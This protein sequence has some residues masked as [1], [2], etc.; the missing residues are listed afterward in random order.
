MQLGT[1]DTTEYM[2]H[3]LK[4][5][6]VKVTEPPDEQP[7]ALVP[8]TQRSSLKRTSDMNEY[9]KRSDIL[10]K[11]KRTKVYKIQERTTKS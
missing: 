7:I 5:S 2:Q 9:M 1:M 11:Q 8:G 10:K 3:E 6:G 4:Q